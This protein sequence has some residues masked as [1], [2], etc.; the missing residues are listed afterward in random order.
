MNVVDF[1][2]NEFDES[3]RLTGDDNRHLIERYRKRW[4][5]K[6]LI[7]TTSPKKIVQIACGTGV[8]TEWL[9][10]NYPEIQ[11]YASDIVPDHIDQLKDY[12][13]LNKCVW[14]CTDALPEEYKDADLVLVEGA[15][16][17]LHDEG[18]HKLLNNLRQINFKLSVIDWL[19]AWHD[20]TQQLLQHKKCPKSFRIPRTSDSPFVFD[21]EQTL[22]SLAT[23]F[24][25]IDL[26][27]VDMDLRFGYI[28]F[29]NVDPAEF[30]KYIQCMNHYINI[31]PS[32]QSFIMNA[33]EHGSYIIH[34]R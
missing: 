34:G 12:P 13:N 4:L 8:H 5:Y 2:T 30:A 31:Y 24:E 17:H 18:R 22:A 19:S 3:N 11:I 28:D 15:W 7:E 23:E 29:N 14:D 32:S 16:Y 9:C 33:T 6:Q 25:H 20:Y 10:E 27:P 1:Y 21:S 26:F